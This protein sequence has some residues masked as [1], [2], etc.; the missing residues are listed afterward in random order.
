MLWIIIAIIRETQL[1]DVISTS[2]Q[3]ARRWWCVVTTTAA[4]IVAVIVSILNKTIKTI[5]LIHKNTAARW[6]NLH[7]LLQPRRNSKGLQNLHVP[8]LFESGEVSGTFD[9]L[10][11]QWTF[12]SFPW[13][14]Y[15][16]IE[17]WLQ[18]YVQFE[19]DNSKVWRPTNQN[20]WRTCS[21][22]RTKRVRTI[23]FE[24]TAALAKFQTDLRI[25]NIIH[26]ILPYHWRNS[27]LLCY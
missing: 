18:E 16:Q 21:K 1:V 6:L 2:S 14:Q 22:V 24:E 27:S 7:L 4:I 23:D 20:C 3:F 9:C 12:L 26:T 11:Y 19:R 15:Y 8:H 10:P 13:Q 17:E 25:Q 5:M